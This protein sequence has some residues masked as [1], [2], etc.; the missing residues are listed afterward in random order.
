MNIHMTDNETNSV[1]TD[2]KIACPHCNDEIKVDALD[3]FD[4]DYLGR[5]GNDE[6][7]S[8]CPHCEENFHWEMRLHL[9]LKITVS[10]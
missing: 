5:E 10:E 9:D 6:Q 1:S 8:T 3:K 7:D 4:F 2:T